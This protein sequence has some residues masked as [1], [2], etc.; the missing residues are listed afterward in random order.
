MMG[1][2]GIIAIMYKCQELRVWCWGE[3][4]RS[5]GNGIVATRERDNGFMER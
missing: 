2:C 1:V 5:D 4:K 3:T